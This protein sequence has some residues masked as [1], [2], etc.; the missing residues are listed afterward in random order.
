LRIKQRISQQAGMQ[1]ATAA[2]TRKIN[3]D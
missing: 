1:T 3:Q 2:A